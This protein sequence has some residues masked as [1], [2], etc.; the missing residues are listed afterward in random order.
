MPVPMSCQSPRLSLIPFHSGSSPLS[1]LVAA[2]LVTLSLTGSAHADFITGFVVDPHGNPVAGVDI[3]VDNL[4]SGGDPDIFNDGTDI[5]GFFFTT[6]PNGGPYNISFRPPAAPLTTL[7]T[8]V[9]E[10]I[11]LVGTLDMGNVVVEQGASLKGTTVTEALFP[12]GNVKLEFFDDAT[13]LEFSPP[14]ATSTLFGTF[15]VTVPLTPFE[16]RFNTTSVI[17]LT[18]APKIQQFDLDANTDIGNV[19]LEQGFHI[20]ATFLKPS[21]LPM[22]FMDTDMF[23]SATGLKV[24]T[25]SDSTNAAGLMDIVVPQGTYDFV[26]CPPVSTGLVAFGFEGIPIMSDLPVGSISLVAGH[27]VSGTVRDGLGNPLAGIDLDVETAT[28]FEIMTCSDTTNALGAYSLILPTGAWTLEMTPPYSLLFGSQTHVAVPVA[29][30]TTVNGVLPDCASVTYGAGLAGFGGVV[31]SL[32]SSGGSC[33][34]GNPNFALEL[35]GGR[36]GAR[37]LVLIGTNPAST[38]FAG[39][40]LLVQ[41]FQPGSPSAGSPYSALPSLAAKGIPGQPPVSI[42]EMVVVRLDGPAG[43]A[44]A[45]NLSLRHPIPSFSALAGLSGYAQVLVRDLSTAQDWAMSNGLQF[46]FCE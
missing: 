7:L 34:F 13:G 29:G 10:G 1:S 16:M 36:G 21:G 33:R 15:E 9:V 38:P 24:Y 44:G 3:D 23:D 42:L 8:T 32:A 18:V 19:V 6:V 4:G 26:A 40:T 46:D 41:G 28:G 5:N 17:G 14:N 39:G 37:A 25:P 2:L 30:P 22:A 27:L 31:P 35:S 43:V 12:V 11:D 20:T 45:G